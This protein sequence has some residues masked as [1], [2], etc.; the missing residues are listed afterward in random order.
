MGW[1]LWR[2]RPARERPSLSRCRS[3]SPPR[4]RRK[5]I[6]GRYFPIEVTNMPAIVQVEHLTKQYKKSAR[7]AVDDISFQVEAGEFF[8]LLGPNGAGKT[9]TISILTTTLAPT[10]GRI[11]IAGYDL[12]REAAEVRR[13]V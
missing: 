7:P 1:S 5:A 2:V 13:R 11:E 12:A 9:T 6:E 4:L 3:S 8:A 10:A